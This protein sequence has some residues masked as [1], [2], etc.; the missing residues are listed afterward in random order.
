LNLR[1]LGYEHPTLVSGITLHR[2]CSRISRDSRLHPIPTSQPN[3][4]DP[5]CPGYTFGY[6]RRRGSPSH[7][8][9]ACPKVPLRWRRHRVDCWRG[10]RPTA[11]LINSRGPTYE[12]SAHCLLES[13]EPSASAL[14]SGTATQPDHVAYPAANL[15]VVHMAERCRTRH[16]MNPRGTLHYGPSRTHYRQSPTMTFSSRDAAV[17]SE[18]E[19]G[20]LFR[21]GLVAGDGPVVEEVLRRGRLSLRYPDFVTP[22]T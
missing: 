20:A 4:A 14:P 18:A 22:G 7:H 10:G 19:L 8:G 13:S 6:T 21:L 12:E 2:K 3:H 17:P 15:E 11:L 5:P 1:P 16:T 9:W